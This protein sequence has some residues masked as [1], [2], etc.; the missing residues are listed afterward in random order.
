MAETKR[1]DTG[2]H[3]G[4]LLAA[5]KLFQPPGGKFVDF[6]SNINPLGTP[7]GLIERLKEAL[8]EIV[9]YPSPLSGELREELG[10]F[11]KVS[12]Q[13]VV[14]GN[15]A[16]D[17]IH[18]LTWWLKPGRV[19]VPAPSFSEYERAARFSGVP[20][21][22]FSLPPVEDFDPGQL[23]SR[24]KEGDLVIF[25][26]PNNP[27]GLLCP[28]LNLV[29]LVEEAAAK[30]ATIMIDESFIPLTAR[31]EESLKDLQAPNLWVVVSLTKIWGLPGLRLGCA[32]GPADLVR[33]FTRWQDPWKVNSL[34]QI[35]GLYC[36][37]ATG[38]IEKTVSL[39]NK[40]RAFLKDFFL[41]TGYFT[42]FD[43]TANYLFLRAELPGFE[44]T[45]FHDSLAKEGVLI[46]K[47]DNFRGLDHRYLRLAVKTRPENL[48]LLE[49]AERY[50]AK[51]A[52]AKI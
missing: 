41:K 50:F 31:P 2:G 43:T 15:G 18:G 14:T 23:L 36:C 37:K 38:F 29:R 17:L 34:A 44:V 24:L 48:K 11:F 47:A 45:H 42:V 21:S 8:P 40:E 28:R 35:A 3:G 16:N 51:N 12:P 10:R 39:V 20:V 22:Y 46:R 26:N 27:T 13:R 30:G 52:G 4:D 25:C 33:E 32:L 6:S 7:P 9:A 19:F 49:E 1:P 5:L